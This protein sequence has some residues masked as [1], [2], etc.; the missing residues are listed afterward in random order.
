MAITDQDL[1]DCIRI[2]RFP[3]NKRGFAFGVIS[4]GLEAFRDHRLRRY[5]GPTGRL[6]K[7]P[8]S[9][10]AATKGRH[11]QEH[12]R[13]VLIAALYRAWLRAFDSAPTLNHRSHPDTPFATFAIHVLTRE[14]IGQ[15]H[16]HLEAYW[17]YSKA[18]VAS[19]QFRIKKWRLSGGSGD[20]P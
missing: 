15:V 2:A 20:C 14:G 10:H 13:F 1:R 9:V 12:P 11:S 6:I 3:F 19:N 8:T 18:E 16:Q 4:A 17:A 5:Y 7:K